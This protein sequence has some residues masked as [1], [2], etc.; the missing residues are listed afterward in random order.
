[1]IEKKDKVVVLLSTYNGE[2][3][4]EEQLRS[5]QAQ[6]G[7]DVSVLVRDDGSAD[8]TVGILDRW[9]ADGKLSWYT[10]ENLGPGKSF[11]HLLE[12][13]EE[14]NYYA[15]CDQDDVWLPDKLR[16]TMDKMRAVELANPGKPVIVHTDMYVVDERLNVIHDSFW[17]SSGLRPDILRTFP[18][19][20][21]CNSVNGCTILMNN[22]ARRLILEKYVEHDVMIH[23]VISALTVAYYGGIIDYVEAPTVLYRQHASNVVGAMSYNKRSAIADRLMNIRSVLSRNIKLFKDVNRIGKINVFTYLY[24]KIKYMLIR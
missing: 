11:I 9:Q 8:G 24:H 1:M 21:I 20:C 17:R 16:I 13:A 18:Y 15:F 19:L 3:Y 6:T 22:A 2:K 23:D 5:L 10:S 4:L 7:V 12:T 14:G